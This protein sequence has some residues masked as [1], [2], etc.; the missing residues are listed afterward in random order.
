[1]SPG[2]SQKT[3]KASPGTVSQHYRPAES[4][5]CAPGVK[6]QGEGPQQDSHA[7]ALTLSHLYLQGVMAN[8]CVG[9]GE[10]GDLEKVGVHGEVR[11][12]PAL[13]ASGLHEW[14]CGSGSQQLCGFRSWVGENDPPKVKL[15]VCVAF[16]S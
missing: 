4:P 14:E 2:L 12:T 3:W 13:P 7:M 9:W 16:D 11:S 6:K 10:K 15:E 5:T 8:N 1:M